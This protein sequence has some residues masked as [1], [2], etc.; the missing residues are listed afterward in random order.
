MGAT[1]EHSPG[2]VHD[3][4]ILGF[5]PT[6]HRRSASASSAVTSSHVTSSGPS[7]RGSDYKPP[8]RGSSRPPSFNVSLNN[9]RPS[10]ATRPMTMEPPHSMPVRSSSARA[11]PRSMYDDPAFSADPTL[12]PHFSRN[13]NN[14]N[15]NN[16][17]LID[18]RPYPAAVNS[19]QPTPAI[20][21]SEIR[22]RRARP[23][24]PVYRMVSNADDLSD[25][26]DAFDLLAPPPTT[27]VTYSLHFLLLGQ[28]KASW[29]IPSWLGSTEDGIDSLIGSSVM[30]PSPKRIRLIQL[31]YPIE[32]P[33]PLRD[34]SRISTSL[35]VLCLG[36]GCC[37]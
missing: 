8:P 28:W 33:L 13:N 10:R 24:A 25:D 35:M 27:E 6:F 14:N 32:V 15:N 1:W 22:H 19:V 30:Y 7:R 17:N 20:H 12:H 29:S 34:L 31:V 26:E 16:N 23:P 4:R 21:V 36:R 5:I 3:D 11:P 37:V 18:P 2:S 9:T